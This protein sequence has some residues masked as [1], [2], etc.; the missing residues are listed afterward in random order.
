VGENKSIARMHQSPL[1]SINLDEFND[2]VKTATLRLCLG[3]VVDVN[4]E[5]YHEKWIVIQKL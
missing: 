2:F 5:E 3:Q 1:S 4:P